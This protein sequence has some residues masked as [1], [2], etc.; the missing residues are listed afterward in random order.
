MT[1]ER[2]IERARCCPQLN[3]TEDPNWENCCNCPHMF[4]ECKNGLVKEL[5]KK[6][7]KAYED[8]K[9]LSRCYTCG[10]YNCFAS[11]YDTEYCVNGE[12][13]WEGDKE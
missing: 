9:D 10:R 5:T 7:G 11:R 12:W 3:E 4:G 13:E 1:T 2:L 6:L 8:L